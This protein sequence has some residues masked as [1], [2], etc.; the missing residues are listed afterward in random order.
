MSTAYAYSESHTQAFCRSS[1]VLL[2]SQ[3]REIT[4]LSQFHIN[5]ISALV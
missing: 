3:A 5:S 1:E 2:F 4:K